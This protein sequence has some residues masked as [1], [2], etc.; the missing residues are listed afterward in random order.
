V[1]RLG[2]LLLAGSIVLGISAKLFDRTSSDFNAYIGLALLAG[3]VLWGA[4]ATVRLFR[5]NLV[6]RPLDALK[7]AAVF[8]V[9]FALIRT[10]F[11]MLFPAVHQDIME[12]IFISAFAALA[13][14]LYS[15]AYRSPA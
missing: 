7:R 3:G 8:L 1:K 11:W 14:G 6:F 13:L 15:T 4:D 2:W 5:G 10:F 9:V 12:A